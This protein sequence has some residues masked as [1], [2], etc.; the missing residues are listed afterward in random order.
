MLCVRLSIPGDIPA[1]RQLWKLAFGDSDSYIDNFYTAYY[2]PERV[3]V[4]EEDGVIRSMTAWFDTTLVLPGAG[5]FRAAYLYAVATHP[6]CRGRGLAAELLRGADDYFR[7]CSIPAVTTVPAQPS[8]HAFFGKNGFEEF[9]TLDQHTL[10]PLPLPDEAPGFPLVPVTPKAYG[11]LR[12]TLLSDLPHVAYPQ[13]ALDYQAGCCAMSG[14]GLY[15][16][17]T[18]RGTAIFCAEGMEDGQL[19]LKELLGPPAAREALLRR[20]PSLLPAFSGV[21]RCPGPSIPFA[22]L[23]FLSASSAPLKG[24]ITAYLGL[25]FD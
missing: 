25:A 2:R 12:E 5:E 3:L 20:L 17:H 19:I 24:H 22:M 4:L 23:K 15:A 11:Q 16:A 14:G 18:G 1:Q 6:D 9:F 13:D 7:A 21:Y 10:D 8:L